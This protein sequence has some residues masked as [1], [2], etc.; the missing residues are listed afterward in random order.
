VSEIIAAYLM[1][2]IESGSVDFAEFEPKLVYWFIE[3]VLY[4]LS[5]RK[6]LMVHHSPRRALNEEMI[7][8]N[9]HDLNPRLLICKVYLPS[10]RSWRQHVSGIELHQNGCSSFPADGEVYLKLFCNLCPY[11]SQ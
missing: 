2:P 7:H 6:D 5:L 11:F 9:Q 3:K 10:F 4:L 8:S 1:P